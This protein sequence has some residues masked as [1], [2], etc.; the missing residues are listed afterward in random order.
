MR[1]EMHY[2]HAKAYIDKQH[3]SHPAAGPLTIR[4]DRNKIKMHAH[5][6][7]QLQLQDVLCIGRATILNEQRA[8]YDSEGRG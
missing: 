5:V 6:C 7:I 8:E 1:M 3:R 4:D 2:L